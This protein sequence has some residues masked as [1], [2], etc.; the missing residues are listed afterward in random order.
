VFRSRA[1]HSPDRPA[2]AHIDQVLA[3]M[4]VATTWGLAKLVVNV[5]DPEADGLAQFRGWASAGHLFV[6]R[7]DANRRVRWRDQSRR[8]PENVEELRTEDAFGRVAGTRG[9]P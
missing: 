9:V 7:V 8:L 2:A 1:D 6:V 5:I 3:T 4:T